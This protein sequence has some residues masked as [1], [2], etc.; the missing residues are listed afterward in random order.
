MIFFIINLLHCNAITSL[1][2]CYSC[3]THLN[4]KTSY[5]CKLNKMSEN[6]LFISYFNVWKENIPFM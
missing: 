4:M 5:V 1:S 2:L 6:S 3:Q